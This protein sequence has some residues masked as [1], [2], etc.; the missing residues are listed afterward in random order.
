M[1]PTHVRRNDQ[2]GQNFTHSIHQIGP[3]APVIVILDETSEPSRSH[4]AEYVYKQS[5]VNTVAIERSCNL[6]FQAQSLNDDGA[7]SSTAVRWGAGFSLAAVSQGE[8]HAKVAWQPPAGALGGGRQRFA[9]PRASKAS[10]KP[11]C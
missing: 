2:H 6:A 1:Y 9:V 7:A 11:A 10:R 8:A 5:Y 4:A 3:K